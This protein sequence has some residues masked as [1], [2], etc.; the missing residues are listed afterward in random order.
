MS[1]G[2]VSRGYYVPG[3]ICPGGKRPGGKCLRDIY[4]L[5]VSVRGCMS[6]GVMS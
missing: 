2:C 3:G 1:R 5:G 6:G 4:A